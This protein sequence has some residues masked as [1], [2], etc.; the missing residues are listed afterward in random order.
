VGLPS[1]FGG[2]KQIFPA[3]R[4]LEDVDSLPQARS[5]ERP[6]PGMAISVELLLFRAFFPSFSGNDHGRT[7]FL[8]CTVYKRYLLF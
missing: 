4:L 6:L 3:G 1:P 2:P 8:L 7:F 5:L